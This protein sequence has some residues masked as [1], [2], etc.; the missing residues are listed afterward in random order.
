MMPRLPMMSAAMPADFS[1]P[2]GAPAGVTPQHSNS[3]PRRGKR[4]A[5]Q[6]LNGTAVFPPP[7]PIGGAESSS[8]S[9]SPSGI[10][11]KGSAGM[12]HPS[13]YT[14]PPGSRLELWVWTKYFKRGWSQAEIG[15]VAGIDRNTLSRAIVRFTPDG[16]GRRT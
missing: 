14:I 13:T 1:L 15:R 4:R 6:T 10:K 7:L 9:R 16:L 5:R 8:Q 11:I 2:P 3:S 12:H